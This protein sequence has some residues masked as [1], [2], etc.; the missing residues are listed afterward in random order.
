MKLIDEIIEL[1]SSGGSDLTAALLKTKVLLHRLGEKEL[2]DWVNGELQGYKSVDNL[3]DYRVLKV[4]VRCTISN[5]SYRHSNQAVPLKHL[6]EETGRLLTT[7]YLAQSIAVIE[8]YIDN[9]NLRITIAPEMYPLLSKAFSN[10][11]HIESAW[12]V[13]SAGA[14]TQVVTEV[15]SRL[16]DFIL[17]L[18]ERFP[19]DLKADELRT[20]S[21]EVGVSDLFNNTVFGDNTTIVVGDSNTQE[22]ENRVVKNDISS[23]IEVLKSYGV[24]DTDIADLTA[25]IDEDKDLTNIESNSFGPNVGDWMGEMVSK[26]ASTAWDVKVGVAGSLLATAIGKFYGF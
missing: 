10:G 26:A 4:I 13:H 19:E 20:K 5:G 12:G 7:D 25:A 16:L 22:V 3:P 2:L 11:Y 9:E 23:L 17:E 18:S 15:T 8:G 14:M 1:L 21:K 24:D 6:E